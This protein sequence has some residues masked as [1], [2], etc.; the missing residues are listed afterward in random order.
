MGKIVKITLE[1]R[2]ECVINRKR[3]NSFVRIERGGIDCS[4]VLLY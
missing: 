2:K 1:E 4:G 3:V